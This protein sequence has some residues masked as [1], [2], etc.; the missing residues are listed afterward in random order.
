MELPDLVSMREFG[1]VL[2]GDFPY[3]T[4]SFDRTRPYLMLKVHWSEVANDY[5]GLKW[6]SPPA[7][8]EEGSDSGGGEG[9]QEYTAISSYSS[10]LKLNRIEN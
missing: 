5:G 2:R 4:F 10:F 9:P 3:L 7:V 6:P 8:V 1:S